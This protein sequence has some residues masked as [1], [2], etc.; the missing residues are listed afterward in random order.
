MGQF[1]GSF[2]IKNNALGGGVAYLY[3]CVFCFM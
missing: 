1:I 2:D 3:R